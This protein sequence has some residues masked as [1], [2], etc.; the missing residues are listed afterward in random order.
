M[1][2][3]DIK[4]TTKSDELKKL[5]ELGIIKVEKSSVAFN[6]INEVVV[7]TNSNENVKNKF[8]DLEKP[9][10]SQIRAEKKV[11][12]VQTTS[13]NF[14]NIQK[15]N[16]MKLPTISNIDEASGRIA[17]VQVLLNEDENGAFGN[18]NKDTIFMPKVK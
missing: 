16:K 10:V 7:F 6:S 9:F 2:Y 4:D 15:F 11:S 3:K 13:S 8:D 5:E 14:D 18:V 17:L 12:V 1:I